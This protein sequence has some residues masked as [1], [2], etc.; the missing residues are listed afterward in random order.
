MLRIDPA[1]ALVWRSPTCVQVGVPDPLVVHEITPAQEH[2]L[3]ALRA[4]VSSIAFD[5]I[6]RM[7]GISATECAQFLSVF[8]PSLQQDARLRLRVG[9]DGS[10]TAADWIAH[11]LG[12]HCEVRAV[13]GAPPKWHP[14]LVVL[15]DSFA[16][17]PARAGVWLSRD[18]PHLGVTLSDQSV[19]VGPLVLP[20]ETACLM[21]A[22]LARADADPAW[23]AILSQLH[24][25]PAGV[26][27][28]L[29][30]MEVGTVVARWV[31]AF[32]RNELEKG[33]VLRL[34]G[35]TG[36]WTA[37]VLEPWSQCSCL[38]LPENGTAAAA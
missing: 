1:L 21:C 6:A 16:I 13:F 24:D 2:L 32:G 3:V 18:I 30:S 27:S 11:A 10:G 26:E 15:V 14:D 4:G 9:V 28:R 33:E 8:R 36:L 5:A 22:E 23:R 34:D 37:D 7:Q 19:R 20:G 38:A 31:Q 29:V 35:A 12:E 17:S 25:R